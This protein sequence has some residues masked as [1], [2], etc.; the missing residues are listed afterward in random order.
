MQIPQ[1][2]YFPISATGLQAVEGPGCPH[3]AAEHGWDPGV[4]WATG[5]HTGRG[6][7]DPALNQKAEPDLAAQSA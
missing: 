5:G 7:V 2:K 3:Q 6:S 4:G 1:E